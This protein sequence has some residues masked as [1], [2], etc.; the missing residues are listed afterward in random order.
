MAM[1][2]RN[3]KTIIAIFIVAAFFSGCSASKKVE[4]QTT[5]NQ[6]EASTQK[7]DKTAT[8]DKKVEETKKVEADPVI[9]QA[10]KEE[11]DFIK[12]HPNGYSSD[13]ITDQ[14]IN[15]HPTK[16]YETYFIIKYK[17]KGSYDTTEHERVFIT[18]TKIQYLLE[19]KAGTDIHEMHVVVLELQSD[20]TFKLI[21]D[22]VTAKNVQ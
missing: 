18:P 21:S 2:R 11:E 4:T 9:L 20:K 1:N 12:S 16:F 7:E 8:S 13:E 5:N 19:V 15:T 14:W 3:I 6:K 17:G 22:T 10:I